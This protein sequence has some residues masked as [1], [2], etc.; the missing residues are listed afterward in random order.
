MPLSVDLPS[1]GNDP[2][3][4]YRTLMSLALADQASLTV[5]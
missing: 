2:E 4:R 5:F 3:I 1:I